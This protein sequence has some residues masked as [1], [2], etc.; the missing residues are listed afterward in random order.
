MTTDLSPLGRAAVQYARAGL[1][2]LPVTERAK[3]PHPCLGAEG[4]FHHA[5]TD[6]AVVTAWWQRYPYANIGA[7]P[8]PCRIGVDADSPAS[9][10]FA[11]RL[12]CF[13]VP[14]RT[15]RTRRGLHLWFVTP[16]GFTLS[17]RTL[18]APDGTG[19]EVTGTGALLLVP[20]SVHPSGHVYVWADR[21]PLGPLPA[22]LLEAL[23]AV[24]CRS[25]PR[26]L[27]PA[28]GSSD[29][30]QLALEALAHLAAWR[31]D[32]Y[33]SWLSV[34]MA[35]HSV[36][37]HLFAA[38]DTWSTRSANYRDNACTRKWRSFRRGGVGLGSL[39]H[40]AEQ[41]APGWRQAAQATARCARY[42][43]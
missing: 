35:L 2:V 12:G 37:G 22:A 31:A 16:D 27:P 4:G 6:G 26:P 13:D 39:L 8:G 32:D 42:A 36:D 25:D 24:E 10:D 15:T 1:A 34:G 9:E 3:R 7:V 19:L 5:T 17:K 21:G 43:A 11:R 14:T 20:P 30:Q 38:W 40:W 28:S 41:D 29:D 18:K 33:S 23:R